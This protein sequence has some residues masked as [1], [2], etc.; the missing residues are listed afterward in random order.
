MKII[1]EI[2]VNHDGDV[3]RALALVD[4]CARAGADYA[5]FQVFRSALL[6]TASA[7]R[8]EYQSEAMGD[9]DQTSMLKALELTNAEFHRLKQHSDRVGI[10]FL[11]T[12]FDEESATFLIDDLGCRTVKIGSGDMD[13]L[14]LLIR[15][16]ARGVALIVSTGMADVDEIRLALDAMAFGR[17]AFE[18]GR[19]DPLA[20]GEFPTR[21]A[22]AAAGRTVGLAGLSQFVTLL[23]CTSEYPARHATLNMLAI[24]SMRALFAPIAIGYSDH[25]TD[26]VAAIMAT[27]LGATVLERHVTYDRRAKGPDHAASLDEAE[28][29]EMI[30]AVGLARAALGSGDKRPSSGET[31]VR[32]VARKRIVAA[33]AMQAG[34][35]VRLVDVALKRASD[36]LP[37][38]ALVDVIGGRLAQRVEIDDPVAISEG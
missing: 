4:A 23:H 17:L 30:R 14:P 31:A 11:A 10:Q 29:T 26:H 12:P 37:A 15:I 38:A 16:A 28:L 27:T 24:P 3:E 6:T 7:K 34:E 35:R 36:G 5:K 25:S 33:R 9:G 22:L 2:G 1:A 18:T 32:A 19:G 13:N 8:A 20:T 21:A